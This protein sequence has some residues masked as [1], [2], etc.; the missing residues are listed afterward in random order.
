M[1]RAEG[2]KRGKNWEN[3][4][5]MINQIYLKKKELGFQEPKPRSFDSRAF[6]F[7]RASLCKSL[8][9][10]IEHLHDF[11]RFLLFREDLNFSNGSAG[12][13]GKLQAE[14]TAKVNGYLLSYYLIQPGLG[15]F[16]CLT[17]YYYIF[18]GII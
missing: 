15:G 13:N 4:N 2:S 7:S 17:T 18:S 5:S 10:N 6:S 11:L 8:D 3:C 9:H 14:E 16:G 12:V 1:C